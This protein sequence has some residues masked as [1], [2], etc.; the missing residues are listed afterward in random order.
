MQPPPAFHRSRSNAGETWL[1]C[2]TSYFWKGRSV[3]SDMTCYVGVN[4]RRKSSQDNV[5]SASST[6]PP[7]SVTRLQGQLEKAVP[8]SVHNWHNGSL[9]KPCTSEQTSTAHRN[10][11]CNS[12]E[13]QYFP[14]STFSP[15][16]PV[17][18]RGSTSSTPD[19]TT[20]SN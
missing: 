5:C 11:L 9:H 17:V 19:N 10:G 14:R 3:F 2:P 7:V 8:C 4:F 12:G 18:L 16:L 6:F 15:H 20:P 13:G 1:S